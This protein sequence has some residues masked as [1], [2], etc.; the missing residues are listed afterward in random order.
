MKLW[1]TA[2]LVALMTIS[3]YPRAANAGDRFKDCDVCPEMVVVPAGS[4]MMGDPEGGILETPVHGV[5]IPQPFAAGVYE[6]T[7]GEFAHFVSETGYNTGA[8]CWTIEGIE[9]TKRKD[10]SWRDP[11]FRQTDRD[12]VVCVSWKDAQ[13]YVSWLS[14][15]RDNTY[16]LFTEAE[17]EYAARSGTRTR[18]WYGDDIDA[19]QLCS[20]GNGAGLETGFSW[21]NK[22]CG[23][24]YERTAPVGSFRAN[25]FGLHDVHGNV[26]EWVEDCWH[27]GYAG[28]P[29]VGRPWTSGSDCGSRVV[30]GGSW[31]LA[32]KFLRAVNRFRYVDDYQYDYI[33]FRVARTL[34]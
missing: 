19:S 7:L 22:A 3:T 10:R 33:G 31:N 2:A 34:P 14:R 11:G 23:D 5:T 18:Y 12:P 25:S 8:S 32:P 15:A 26:W 13:A 30:R 16:R 20:Y 17:W 28:A 4:F 29:A 1:I 21:Q 24:G 27:D 6:V 9:L